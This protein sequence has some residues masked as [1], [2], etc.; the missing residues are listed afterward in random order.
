MTLGPTK[1]EQ[2]TGFTETQSNTKDGAA[3]CEVLGDRIGGDCDC[4]VQLGVSR[5][6]FRGSPDSNRCLNMPS[7]SS[8]NWLVDGCPVLRLIGQSGLT[9]RLRAGTQAYSPESPASSP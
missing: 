5:R 8:D 9:S 7:E 2:R 1:P 4:E 3:A 6:I